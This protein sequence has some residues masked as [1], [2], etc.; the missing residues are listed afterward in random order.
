[1]KPELVTPFRVAIREM[2]RIAL[3][4][5]DTCVETGNRT[6][7]DDYLIRMDYCYLEVS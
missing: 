7:D 4:M 1:M 6:D 5:L 3:K 2:P